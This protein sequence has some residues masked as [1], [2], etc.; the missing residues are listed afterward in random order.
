M[1]DPTSSIMVTIKKMLGIAQEYN[2]FDVDIRVIINSVFLALNQLGVGPKLPF[3]ITGPDETWSDFLGDQSELLAGVETYVYLKTRLIFDPPT[4][5]FIVDAYKKQCDEFEWRFN[6]QVENKLDSL[7]EED[8]PSGSS[9]TQ[10]TDVFAMRRSVSSNREID[11]L[12]K[13]WKAVK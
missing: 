8:T 2:A 3:Q 5:S 13:R 11:I 6:Q 1:G 7:E 10:P 12:K 4:N 9:N